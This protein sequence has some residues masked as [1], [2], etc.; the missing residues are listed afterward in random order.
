MGPKYVSQ[1]KK[2]GLIFPK[3]DKNHIFKTYMTRKVQKTG[4]F[5]LF[6]HATSCL[7]SLGA[8]NRARNSQNLYHCKIWM[9]LSIFYYY[10]FSIKHLSFD[11]QAQSV[12]SR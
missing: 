8:R 1:K 10:H 12:K 7:A 2:Y 9:I 11:V 6:R 5:A 4:I 3:M